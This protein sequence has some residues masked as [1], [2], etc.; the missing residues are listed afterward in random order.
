MTAFSATVYGPRPLD[1]VPPAGGHYTPAIEKIER[2]NVNLRYHNLLVDIDI[3]N[4]VGA[5][6]ITKN[7]LR[8]DVG[9]AYLQSSN[10]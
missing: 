9:G 8:P 6:C 2:N 3:Y 10:W 1:A 4:I 7:V 5:V